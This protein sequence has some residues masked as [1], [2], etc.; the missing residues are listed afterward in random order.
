M[1]RTPLLYSNTTGKN[2]FK[3]ENKINIRMFLLK[4]CSSEVRVDYACIYYKLTRKY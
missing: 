3:I 2:T 1:N 4:Y